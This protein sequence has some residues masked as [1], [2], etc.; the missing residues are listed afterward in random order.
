MGR[1]GLKINSIIITCD[2]CKG[3]GKIPCPP[4]MATRSGINGC[5]NRGPILQQGTGF[6]I[7][8]PKCRGKKVINA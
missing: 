3:K 2:Y 1:E 8:C 6:P 5:N 4:T 7:P